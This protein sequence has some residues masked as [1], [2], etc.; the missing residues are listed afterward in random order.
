MN[1][2]LFAAFAVVLIGTLGNLQAASLTRKDLLQGCPVPEKREFPLSKKVSP[3][4][5]FHRYVCEEVESKFKL[6]ADRSIWYFSFSDNSERILYAKKQFFKKVAQGYKLDQERIGKV[7]NFYS[8]CMNLKGSVTSEQ[9]FVKSEVKSLVD[10]K[11]NA[12]F[13]K[14]VGQNIDQP[15]FSGLEFDVIPNLTDPTRFDVVI[16]PNLMTFPERSFY[17]NPQALKDLKDLAEL[18]YKQVGVENAKS[19]AESLVQF[20]I[21]FSKAFPLPAEFRNLIS[22]DTY[23]SKKFFAKNY[24]QLQLD[25][26]LTTIPDDVKIRNLAPAAML[27]YNKLLSEGNLET[28][29]S[30][31]LFHE[32]KDVIDDAYPQFQKMQFE[33]DRKYKG[34]PAKRPSRD[35][36]CTKLVMTAF[37]HEIDEYLT[38]ILFPDFP[39]E[40]VVTLVG[41]I[42]STILENLEANT[43]LSVK[44]KTEAINKMKNA[45]L[46]LVQPTTP[47][48]WDFNPIQDYS[49]SAP[50][51]NLIKLT[52]IQ[53]DKKINEL[54]S[55]RSRERWGY[56]PLTLNAYYAP[57]DNQFVLLQGILQPPFYS[58]DQSELE[59]LGAIG[60]VVGHELGHGIDDHGSKYD[61][62]G[63]LKQWM[64]EKDLIEFRKRGEQFVKRFDAVKHNGALTLGENI[65]DHVG[66]SSSYRAALDSGLLKTPEDKKNFFKAY[67]RL[68]CNV[69]RPEFET[70]QLKTDSHSLG[71]ERINQQVVHL[72]G[73]YEA[74]AC[75]TKDKLY[76]APSERIK[77]W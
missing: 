8:A 33:F 58:V 6:P 47:A 13:Q 28:L 55:T 60:S 32:L 49:K 24:P 50:I 38:S 14:R 63:R 42:R 45:K 65:G 48:E 74:Y 59:N 2:V 72:D 16:L 46:F 57:A 54:K 4:E 12:D 18:L 3:C 30:V 1:F 36:R 73:F 53:I 69:S 66:I 21:E 19:K 9:S 64:T 22:T 7:G 51:D 25:R 15:Y 44:A 27:V 61:S 62:M 43:W 70:M 52:K 71:R 77:I 56:G 75:Q 40:K 20:E 67:A 68:W 76:V 41:N 11:T 31:A 23:Q 35:E 10:L 17:E 39:R 26:F 34:G 29:Q 5:D 37:P